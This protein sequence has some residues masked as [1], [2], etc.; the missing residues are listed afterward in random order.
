[1]MKNCVTITSRHEEV[2]RTTRI[3]VHGTTSCSDG[4]AILSR[5]WRTT[6]LWTMT[7][8]FLLFSIGLLL[9]FAASPPLAEKNGFAPSVR[10]ICEGVSLKSTS[11]VQ[12]H[13]EKLIQ[14]GLLQKKTKYLEKH[15]SITNASFSNNNNLQ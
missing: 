3:T 1:M 7:C 13:L 9:G 10:E 11:T 6:D 5:W 4:E 2:G 12:Y 14:S 8:I 15:L